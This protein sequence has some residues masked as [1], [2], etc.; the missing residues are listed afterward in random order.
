MICG[1][2]FVER[3]VASDFGAAAP[4]LG[5]LASRRRFAEMHSHSH[6][7]PGRRRS[8]GHHPAFDYFQVIHY[9]RIRK[10]NNQGL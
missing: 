8:Q 6:S 2:N 7:P 9:F 5:A 3:R 1:G 4:P 10:T